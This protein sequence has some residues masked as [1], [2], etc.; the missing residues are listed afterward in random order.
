MT[1]AY[2]RI[3]ARNLQTGDIFRMFDTDDCPSQHVICRHKP[4]LEIPQSDEEIGRWLSGIPFTLERLD[5]LGRPYKITIDAFD[6][7]WRQEEILTSDTF[8]VSRHGFL[9]DWP[10]AAVII[11]AYAVVLTLAVIIALVWT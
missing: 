1:L 3:L 7:C 5:D 11:A 4:S 6:E 2:R 9:T 8:P 10:S